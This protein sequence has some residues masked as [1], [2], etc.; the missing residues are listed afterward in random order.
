MRKK[1]FLFLFPVRNNLL[2]FRSS[3]KNFAFENLFGCQRR[4]SISFLFPFPNLFASKVIGGEKNV[5]FLFTKRQSRNLRC[6]EC[7][8]MQPKKEW[9]FTASDKIFSG[10]FQRRFAAPF[11]D[12]LQWVAKCNPIENNNLYVH[13]DY[14]YHFYFKRRKEFSRYLKKSTSDGVN[15]FSFFLCC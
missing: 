14:N 6:S 7:E 4:V 9:R 15:E 2:F 11:A 3:I 8:K 5:S 13:C 12:R 1:N 10:F